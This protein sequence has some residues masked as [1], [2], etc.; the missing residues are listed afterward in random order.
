MLQ[1]CRLKNYQEN[2]VEGIEM[3]SHAMICE[4]ILLTSKSENAPCV[5]PQVLDEVELRK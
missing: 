2:S 1:C 5:F 4:E 3:M